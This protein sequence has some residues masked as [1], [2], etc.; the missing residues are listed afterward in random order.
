MIKPFV[1]QS[2]FDIFSAEFEKVSN[3]NFRDWLELSSK[4]EVVRNL[5]DITNV[6]PDTTEK[7]IYSKKYMFGGTPMLEAIN[8]SAL[9]FL[10]TR[11][12]GFQKRLLVISDGEYRHEIEVKQVST[13]LKEEGVVVLCGYIGNTSIIDTLRYSFN[14]YQGKGADNLMDIASVVEEFPDIVSYIERG[15]I[16]TDLKNKLCIQINHPKHL[17]SL[18]ESITVS[19]NSR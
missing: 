7:T 14:Q 19:N 11:F 18:V 5:S 4:R 17:A 9:R 12:K 2:V 1:E 10:D 3:E 6:L 15:E 8:L 13:L 16:Q